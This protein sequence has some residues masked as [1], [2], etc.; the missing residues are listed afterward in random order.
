MRTNLRKLRNT[1]LDVIFPEVRQGLLATLTLDPDRKWYLGEVARHLDVTPSS[2]QRELA[3]LTSSGILIQT[4][5]GNRVYYQANADWPLLPE[6]RSIF[7]KTIGLADQVRLALAPYAHE[8][9]YAFLFGSTVTAQSWA[10]SDID[11]LII[12]NV[13][14]RDLA[15]GLSTAESR[16]QNTIDVMLFTHEEFA[17]KLSE[18]VHFVT[19]VRSEPKIYLVGNEAEFARAFGAAPNQAAHDKQAG[20]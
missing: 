1:T 15:S 5:E 14:M 19:A 3:S 12:G 13:K 16:L 8:I 17:T 10:G 4:R 18:G 6:V 20:A 9:E 11:L 2:L 7:V